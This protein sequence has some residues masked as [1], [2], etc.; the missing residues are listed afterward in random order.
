M[1]V[2]EPA[3]TRLPAGV[4]VVPLTPHADE[5][6]VLTEIHRASWG[7]PKPVQW[8]LVHSRPGTLRGVHLHRRHWDYL[9]LVAGRCVYGL[10]DLRAGDATRGVAV[11]ITAEAERPFALVLP[12]GVAHGFYFPVASTHVYG[13]THYWDLADELGCR[14]DDPELGIDW[15]THEVLLSPRDRALPSLR[16]LLAS[17][18]L[19]AGA[20]D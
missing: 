7:V 3:A 9:V 17:P 16:E 18:A 1:A 8:N 14:F 15:P 6:G 11:T 4:L 10:R 20:A 2:P 13:V 19:R 5:R 12:P